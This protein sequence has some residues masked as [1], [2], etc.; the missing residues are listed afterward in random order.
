MKR[1]LIAFACA[2]MG[3]AMVEARPPSGGPGI[4]PPR[5]H[6]SFDRRPPKWGW[7]L[8]LSPWGSSISIGHRVGRHGAVGFTVPLTPPPRPVVREER[9]VVV[10]QPAVVQQP[11]IVQQPVVVQQPAQPAVL[12]AYATPQKESGQAAARTWVEGYWRVARDPNGNETSRVWV[13]GHWE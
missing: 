3:A 1:L 2:A 6:Y 7:G 11:V 10:Q 13:P 8:N 5:G 9:V 12:P 4:P